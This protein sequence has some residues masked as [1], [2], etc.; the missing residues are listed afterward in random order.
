MKLQPQVKFPRLLVLWLVSKMDADTGAVTLRNGEKLTVTEKD[1]QIVLG[2]PHTNM[3][4]ACSFPIPTDVICRV[5]DILMLGPEEEITLECLKVILLHDYG[6]NMTIREIEAFKVALVLYV[7]AYFMGPKGAKVKV[8]QEIFRNVT[9]TECIGKLN[10]CGYVLRMLLQ[11]A[12][13]VQKSMMTLN[14]TVTLDGCLFFWV[15]S[16]LI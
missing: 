7:D 16:T 10:W 15:V 3:L 6:R 2:L 1:V 4:V 14:K 9:D 8:N 12:R 11:S 5:R 13:R